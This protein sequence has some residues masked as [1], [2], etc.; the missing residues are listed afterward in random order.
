[1]FELHMVLSGQQDGCLVQHLH[2]HH[3]TLVEADT[4]GY[5]GVVREGV[6]A[7]QGVR[8]LGGRG[9]DTVS[10]RIVSTVHGLQGLLQKIIHHN[11]HNA[12]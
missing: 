7:R 8:A 10:I 4:D 1:M 9:T 3:G 12:S 2:H 11:V 6:E 5:M